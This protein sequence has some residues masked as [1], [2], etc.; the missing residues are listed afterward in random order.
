MNAAVLNALNSQINAELHASYIYLSMAA[1]FDDTNLGGFASWMRMQ[2]SEELAHA[3]KI[4]DYVNGRGG[5]VKLAAIGAPPVDYASPLDAF[6]QS[7]A[8]EQKVTGLINDLYALASEHNDYPTQV[9]LQWFIEEQVE[10][11]DTAGTI[12][13]QLE[14][15]G[16]N[17]ATLLVMD[18]QM[19]GRGSEQE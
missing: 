9:M 14:M 6:K 3:M 7:L 1:Y 2:S 4:F 10:E 17:P 18:R 5:R 13:A 12:V 8:H 16:D 11:E 19:A 15:I